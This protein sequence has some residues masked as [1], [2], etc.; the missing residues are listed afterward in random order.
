MK[1]VSPRCPSPHAAAGAR[2]ELA[3]GVC[4]AGEAAPAP[5][6]GCWCTFLLIWGPSSLRDVPWSMELALCH[7]SCSGPG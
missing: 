4:S 5:A 6:R 3:A 1:L 2:Q 7:P